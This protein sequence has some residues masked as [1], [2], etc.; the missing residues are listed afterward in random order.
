MSQKHKNHKGNNAPK[1][2]PQPVAQPVVTPAAP[3]PVAI[4]ASMT[5]IRGVLIQVAGGRLLLPNATIAEVLSY[6]MP[7]PVENAPS[8]LLG[9]TRWRGYRLPMIAFSQLAGLGQ[10]DA[11][12]GTKVIVLKALGGHPRLPYFAMVTHGFPRLVTVTRDGLAIETDDSA[13]LPTGI[14]ARVRLNED[15]AFL[16]DLL[17]VE[18][19]IADAL[20]QAEAA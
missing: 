10:E 3:A 2:A 14:Q 18:K 20:S 9:R 12:L 6:S 13:A 4:P 15:H 8:W 17:A 11:G 19:L 1:S 5:D 7:D 16:P